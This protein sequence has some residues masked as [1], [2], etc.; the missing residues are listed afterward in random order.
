M[1]AD[2]ASPKSPL[3]AAVF[4]SGTGTNAD[5]IMDTCKALKGIDITLIVTNNPDA[6]VIARAAQH[7]IPCAVIARA[8]DLPVRAAKA[9]QEKEILAALDG[10]RIDW[11]FLA[12]FMQLLSADFLRHFYDDARGHNRAVNI[13]PSLLPDFAGK[14]SYHR[15]YDAGGHSH[16]VT[17]HYVDDGMD[18]GPVIAQASYART[19][20]MDFA[21][22]C[23]AGQQ[24]E[25]RLYADFLRTLSREHTGTAEEKKWAQA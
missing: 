14:D 4:A 3:R 6:G 17:L 19:A 9:Q 23:A 15:A 13:H 7:G 16:G 12:G 11:L 1:A 21:A 24:L 18:T 22:F 25:Y 20:D 5:N 8:Q 10:A 2:R